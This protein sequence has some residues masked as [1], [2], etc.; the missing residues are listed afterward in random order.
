MSSSVQTFH[1]A[2]LIYFYAQPIQLTHLSVHILH[3]HKKNN[4]TNKK[5]R[6]EKE[7]FT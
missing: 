2:P 4:Q 5:K 7:F 3:T 6:K 1:K